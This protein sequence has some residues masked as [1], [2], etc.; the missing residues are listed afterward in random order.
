MDSCLELLQRINITSPSNLLLRRH[1][2]KCTGSKT[3][4]IF[5]LGSSANENGNGPLEETRYW[6][7]DLPCSTRQVSNENMCWRDRRTVGGWWI[8]DDVE[9]D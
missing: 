2:L 4:K 8:N 6:L 3:D 7:V 5:A 9:A 1:L